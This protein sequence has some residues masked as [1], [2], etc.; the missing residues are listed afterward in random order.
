MTLN[1]VPPDKTGDLDTEK[2]EKDVSIDE[3][4]PEVRRKSLH[5]RKIMNIIL[6]GKKP[7]TP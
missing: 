2:E 5:K 3:S 7:S 1:L 6:Q 4:S